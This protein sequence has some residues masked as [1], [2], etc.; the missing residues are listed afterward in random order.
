MGGFTT[1]VSRRAGSLWEVIFYRLRSSVR[2]SR[3]P[4]DTYSVP[5][6]HESIISQSAMRAGAI[7]LLS[8]NC[9]WSSRV[10][11]RCTERNV[12]EHQNSGILQWATNRLESLDRRPQNAGIPQDIGRSSFGTLR[13]GCPGLYSS[14]RRFRSAT[15]FGLPLA[16][17]LRIRSSRLRKGT[18]RGPIECIVRWFQAS[19][20]SRPLTSVRR[21]ILLGG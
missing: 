9:P 6:R 17:L 13:L 12:Y 16:H 1:P 14:L 7:L 10:V 11:P 21:S 3:I 8:R 15:S 19:S 2:A 4:V 20:K 5:S 18:V